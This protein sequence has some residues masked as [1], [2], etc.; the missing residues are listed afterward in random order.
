MPVRKLYIEDNSSS[1]FHQFE[2]KFNEATTIS[3]TSI[4]YG[5]GYTLISREGDIQMNGYT[6][7]LD[8]AHEEEGKLEELVSEMKQIGIRFKEF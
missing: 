6:L 1:K 4:L 5:K 7:E 2:K 8:I 3:F